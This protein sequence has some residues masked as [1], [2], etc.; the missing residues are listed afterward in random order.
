MIFTL[1]FSCIFVLIIGACT[2]TVN[3]HVGC[4]LSGKSKDEVLDAIL[5]LFPEAVAVQ[6]S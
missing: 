4:K 1:Y 6:Q 5:A 3:V 2:K